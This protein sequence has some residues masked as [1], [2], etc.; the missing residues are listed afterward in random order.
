MNHRIMLVTLFLYILT[1][2]SVIRW[3]KKIKQY[4][5][6]SYQV[7]EA[8]FLSDKEKELI[9]SI[10]RIMEEELESRIDDFS[11]AVVIAQIELLLTY[12]ERFYKRQFITRKAVNS[13][14]LTRLEEMMEEYFNSGEGAEKG[15]PGVQYFADQLNL[16]A[17]YLSD[18]LR[19]LTG[20]NA[21]QLIHHKII[22][23]AKEILSTTEL[24]VAEIAFQLG[25]D[26]PQSFS[27]LF[28][29]KTN[30]SPVAFRRSFN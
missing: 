5:F 25:F 9:I 27:R 13:E 8:L 16:S 15:I 22:E 2:C 28:K 19:S 21:Q 20:Q 4:G 7:A 14:L 23:K 10:F 6:F 26:Y 24:S 1:F 17:S 11:Q 18:M 12:A 29:A 3:R 30:I